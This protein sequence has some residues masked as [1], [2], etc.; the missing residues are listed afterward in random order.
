MIRSGRYD[1]FSVVNGRL[2]LDGGAMFGVVPRGVWSRKAKPD[3]LNRIQLAMRTLVAM[4]RDAG[5]V[6][7]VDTGAGHKWPA[8]EAER[9]AIQPDRQALARALAEHGLAETDVTD[10]VITH[11]HFDHNGGLTEWADQPGGPT[12]L[13]FPQARHW[14]HERHWSHANDPNPRDQASFLERDIHALPEPGVLTLVTGDE[15]E[16]PFEGLRWRRCWCCFRA[17]AKSCG[18]A[19]WAAPCCT[20]NGLGGWASVGRRPL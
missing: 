12:R 10:V 13:R 1:I 18:A 2:G 14:I 7:L 20:A 8:E 4:D 16:P 9:F 11:L 5:R 15:P 17:V 3:E 6:I 19:I